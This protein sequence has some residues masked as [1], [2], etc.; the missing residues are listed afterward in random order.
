MQH[1]TPLRLP[2][3]VVFVHA[4]AVARAA[5]PPVVVQNTCVG[6]LYLE[7]QL[8]QERNVFEKASGEDVAFVV[9]GGG[10]VTQ[11]WSGKQSGEGRRKMR[12]SPAIVQ[13]DGLQHG[14]VIKET[15]GEES[16]ILRGTHVGGR[17][18]MKLISVILV[19]GRNQ[20]GGFVRVIERNLEGR[21]GG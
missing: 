2:G 1:H 4:A 7:A 13:V 9:S 6:Y 10:W 16:E 5:L 21:E 14:V 18:E 3:L 15:R 20:I 11:R 19:S 8:L 12:R 17:F